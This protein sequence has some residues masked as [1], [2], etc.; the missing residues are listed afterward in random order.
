[1][2][3][4]QNIL[5]IIRICRVKSCEHFMCSRCQ[6]SKY[7]NC[8]GIY[9]PSNAV[10]KNYIGL[11]VIVFE[12]HFGDISNVEFSKISV[13]HT[14]WT[15]K[16]VFFCCCCRPS[17][18]LW[19]GRQHHEISV[20]INRW[21]EFSGQKWHGGVDLCNSGQNGSRTGGQI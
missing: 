11:F 8:T 14:N 3:F 20:Q 7:L 12:M 18:Y 13:L 10:I 17:F 9:V 4:H 15:V 6:N 1:M 19:N 2:Y 21:I 5:Q 16:F